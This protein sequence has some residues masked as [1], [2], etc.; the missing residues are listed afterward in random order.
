MSDPDDGH[1]ASPAMTLP[2]V[3]GIIATAMKLED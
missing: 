3:P 1:R 2:E